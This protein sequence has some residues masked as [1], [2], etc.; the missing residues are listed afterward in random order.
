[1]PEW[2][3]NS[4]INGWPRNGTA[5]TKDFYPLSRTIYAPQGIPESQVNPAS[6]SGWGGYK[7]EPTP[8]YPNASFGRHD[9]L[10]GELM[11]VSQSDFYNSD[12]CPWPAAGTWEQPGGPI[13]AS[14]IPRLQPSTSAHPGLASAT[15]AGP[16][17][18]FVAPPVFTVQSQPIY[19]VGL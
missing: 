14:K 2:R 11:A 3:Q 1:M 12:P 18:L 9:G 19:A 16:T 10:H 7:A 4:T 13:A 8:V 17:M 15:G 6:T 5:P